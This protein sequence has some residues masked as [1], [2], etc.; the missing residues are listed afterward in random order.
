[1]VNQRGMVRE[2][3][4][5]PT[6]DGADAPTAK[7]GAKEEAGEGQNVLLKNTM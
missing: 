2:E 7:E 6:G 5:V 1:M 4:F 3:V